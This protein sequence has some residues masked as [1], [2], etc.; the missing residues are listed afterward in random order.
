MSSS[1]S[2]YAHRMAVTYG[3]DICQLDRAGR[4]A[5][6]SQEIINRLKRENDDEREAHKRE[7]ERCRRKAFCMD[8][9]SF[10]EEQ[11]ER[12]NKISR[13]KGMI[14]SETHD[15]EYADRAR[16]RG[17]VYEHH[18]DGFCSYWQNVRH[19][20]FCTVDQKCEG[21]G[22]R[23]PLEGH[24]RDDNYD[25]LGFEEIG[26]LQALCRKCHEGIRSRRAFR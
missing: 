4:V 1:E 19:R 22:E 25:C 11:H 24:H 16:A 7:C 20:K 2:Q 12:W 10:T 18:I 15:Q 6:P 13:L 23:R 8:G 14:E 26:D 9:F 21:C 17:V 3:P 5:W